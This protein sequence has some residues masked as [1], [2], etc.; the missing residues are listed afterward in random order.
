MCFDWD[1]LVRQK[2]RPYLFRLSWLT[3]DSALLARD[4]LGPNFSPALPVNQW[5]LEV[6]RWFESSLVTMQTVIVEY[7]H[8][9]VHPLIRILKPDTPQLASQCENQR[10]QSS[11][12]VQSFSVLGLFIV[13]FVTFVTACVA[14]CLESAV[15][16]V[17]RFTKGGSAKMIARQ[18][19]EKLHLARMVQEQRA[20][21]GDE[22]QGWTNGI[23]EVPVANLDV[24]VGSPVMSMNN[25]ARY[26]MVPAVHIHHIPESDALK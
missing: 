2:C 12:Q 21:D 15:A 23:L 26:E 16:F 10:V 19:D 8:N 22:D 24:T 17:R 3:V 9:T 20:Y 13:V 7:A 11:G 5:K 18:T 4:V 1:L 25:L 6:T 14:L